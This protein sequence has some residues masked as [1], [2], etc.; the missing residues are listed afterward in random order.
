M[1][2]AAW[3][4]ADIGDQ[5]GRTV[6]VTGANSG[7][8]L[9]AAQIL[10]QRGATVI[11]AVRTVAKG[12]AAARSLSDRAVVMHLDL[13]DLASVRAFAEEFLQ[14]NERL[15]LL[16]NNAGIMMTPK[17]ETA[18]GFELQ[19]G[20]NHLGH[21][22]L[23]GLLLGPL[24]ATDSSRVVTISSMAHQ[25]GTLAFDNLMF[26][27]G[28]YSPMAAYGRSKLANLVF[29]YE[30][31][32]RLAGAGSST[33]AIAAHPGVSTTSLGDHLFAK[34]YSKPLKP[35]LSQI[36]QSADKGALPTLR[37]ATDPG[38]TGGEYIGP[39]GFR[40][41]RGNPVVVGSSDASTS[42]ENGKRLWDASVELTGVGYEALSP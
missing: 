16:V 9:E 32:R 3:T 41:Y 21:F 35:V 14:N 24:L 33:V 28:G 11:L 27:G 7:I 6:V 10:D 37:A 17:A 20:T 25:S 22:A 26:E 13:G 1:K 19:F 30:L 4:T 39:A 2:P 42:E 12:E 15:D 36:F 18:D 5:T 40:E 34:W 29:S 31:Q 8:G 23:T 38:L